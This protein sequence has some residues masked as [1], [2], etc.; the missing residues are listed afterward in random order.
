MS[1]VD[2]DLTSYCKDLLHGSGHSRW[3][4]KSLTLVTFNNGK[5]NNNYTNKNYTNKNDLDYSL[6]IQLGIN[7]EHSWADAPIIGYLLEYCCNLEHNIGYQENGSCNGRIE[8]TPPKPQR[9][10]WNMTTEVKINF[11]S[12]S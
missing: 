7:A 10:E 11:H 1:S 6:S 5:V 2:G 4:D 3:F 9:L 12:C 8:T